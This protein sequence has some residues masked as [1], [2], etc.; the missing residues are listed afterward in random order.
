MNPDAALFHMI[1]DQ[2][3]TFP[4]LDGLARLLVNDF[5]VPTIMSLA[6][7][8]LWLAGATPDER[9]RNQRA[10]VLIVLGLALANTVI[11]E[12]SFVYFRPRPFATDA[13]KLLF[14]RPSVSSFPSVPIATAFTFAAG[15]WYARRDVA[16]LLFVLA[17]LYGLARVY[18]GVHYPLDVIGG[19]A[20]GVGSVYLVARFTFIVNP[21]ADAVAHVARRLNYV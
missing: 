9:R 1:N 15:A 18:A 11:K 14:Y 3:G 12:L 6:A 19:A 21:I 4:I 16:K 2:V 13:V 17:S 20:I 10:V 5:V 8:W 7:V